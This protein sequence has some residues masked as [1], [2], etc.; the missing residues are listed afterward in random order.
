MA[1]VLVAGVYVANRPNTAAH[2]IH[3][4]ASS[5]THWVQQRWIGLAPDGIGSFDLPCTARVVTRP[6]PKFLLLDEV[7]Q[8]AGRFDWILL[9]DD[10]V[11]FAPG[12][13]DEFIHWVQRCDFALAQPARTS[14]S[15]IDHPIVQCLGGVSARRTRFVEI[16]PVVC[17]RRDAVPLLMPFGPKA[18]MG[19]GLDFIWPALLEQAGLRAGI[20]DAAPMA[21]R[22]RPA[23][24][25]YD[26]SGA[27]AVMAD[28][29]A[30]SPHLSRDEAFLVLEAYT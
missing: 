11:E 15:Y 8:D 18:G 29:L 30:L 14:D 26:S 22:M 23:A 25:S 27:N 6:Q 5:R 9:C 3:E 7:T 17:I 10:D 16:G 2:V 12:F 24:R 19:W 1:E 13:L 4:L 20:I 28:L 21:H